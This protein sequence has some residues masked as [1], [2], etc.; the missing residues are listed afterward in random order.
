MSILNEFMQ[1]LFSSGYNENDRK[2]ILEGGF[3]TYKKLKQLELKGLWPF[4][5]P[6]SFQKH[7]RKQSK[8]S[9]INSW[10][11]QKENNV[12]KTVM[13]VE[14]TPGDQLLKLIKKVEEKY[15]IGENQRI[16]FV[17]KNGPKLCHLLERKD[18]FLKNCESGVCRPC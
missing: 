3:N 15:M 12:Y 14:A 4:Y 17:T 16:K 9:K 18:P 8:L 13:F 10:Y 7:K 1:D 2:L 11:K 6:N 5:R